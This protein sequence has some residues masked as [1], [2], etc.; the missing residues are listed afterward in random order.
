MKI[1][2]FIG[3]FILAMLLNTW[4]PPVQALSHYAVAFARAC[5]TLTLFLIGCGL[6]GKLLKAVGFKPLI[7]GVLLWVFI[8]V[9]ALAA[10][11]CLI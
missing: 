4:F 6:S 3:L 11:I 1:P 9:A 2:W 10:V 5:L 7:H 8:S